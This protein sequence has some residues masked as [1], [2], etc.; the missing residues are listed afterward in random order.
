VKASL[1]PK[2]GK[3]MFLSLATWQ[4]VESRLNGG[5]RGVIVPIGSHEQHGPTG[6]IGTDAL[7][8]EIIA[9]AAEKSGDLLIAPTFSVGMA[10]HHMGF[11]GS[12]TLRPST[13][14]ATI[15]D[16]T[17][18]FVRAG[19][20]RIYWINGHGGNVATI[21]AAFAET[22]APYSL[23]GEAAPFAH[24][25]KNW[26]DLPG[27]E[28]LCRQLF[29][30]GHGSHGTASEIALTYWAYPERATLAEM[31]LEPKIAPDGPIRDAADYRAR[32]ADGRIGSDPTQSKPE[33]GAL[34]VETAA[35]GLIGDAQA[36][37]A[38]T[39]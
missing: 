3:C 31:V 27:L 16:W 37:F 39:Q 1:K 28:A 33:Q 15:V 24:K 6:L 23:R 21:Q 17:A 38:E 25:L 36:F 34:L 5:Q 12:M 29:P 10:Q 35:K 8:P 32:F 11:P 9:R 26:W 13:M 19:F 18:S 7:C 20:D 4:E 14:M 22:Y 30:V 2:G